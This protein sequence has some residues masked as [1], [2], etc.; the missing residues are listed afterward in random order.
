MSTRFCNGSWHRATGRMGG[1]IDGIYDPKNLLGSL[2]SDLDDK[3]HPMLSCIDPYGDTTFNRLQMRW[4]LARVDRNQPQHTNS[5]AAGSCLQSRGSCQALRR[6]CSHL[7]EVH[8]RLIVGA[9]GE[10][11]ITRLPAHGAFPLTD[12]LYEAS[13]TASGGGVGWR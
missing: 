12:T 4:F 2:L 13:I 1:K 10:L 5:R 7:F 11:P 6:R 3:S 9:C 8:W